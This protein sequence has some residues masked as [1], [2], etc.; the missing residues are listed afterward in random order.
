MQEANSAR[1]R[2][3]DFM[4]H[5][6]S[7]TK[8]QLEYALKLQ[9]ASRQPLGNILTELGFVEE[10]TLIDHLFKMVPPAYQKEEEN[11]EDTHSFSELETLVDPNIVPT[12]KMSFCR[13]KKLMPI[14]LDKYGKTLL[15]AMLDPTDQTTLQELRF[16][17]N[18]QVQPIKVNLKDLQRLWVLFHR[19][20]GAQSDQDEQRLSAQVGL[21]PL[22]PRLDESNVPAFVDAIIQQ[23]VAF[24]ASDVHIDPFQDGV[25]IRFRIDGALYPVCVLP[26]KIY[27]QVMT[28]FKVMSQMDISEQRRAQEG[29]IE[30]EVKRSGNRVDLRVAMIPTYFGERINFRILD[31]SG[32]DL[33]LSKLGI[34]E[35][36]MDMVLS[37]LAMRQG[38][39]LITGPTGSGKTTTIYSMLNH[40]ND[41]SR[42][43]M[44]IED[45][46]E[47]LVKGLNQIQID[48]RHDISFNSVL[49][50]LLR[51]NPDVILV[52]EIRDRETA[53]TAIR[54]ALTG[55][56]II[57]TV[58]TNDTST[59][60]ARLL[61]L[62]VEPYLLGPALQMVMAQRLVRKI[63]PHCKRHSSVPVRDLLRVGVKPVEVGDTPFYEGEGCAKCSYTGILGVSG[64]YEVMPITK[65]LRE[66]IMQKAP[67]MQI[68]ALALRQGMVPLRAGALSKAIC[69]ETTLYE[70]TRVAYN[71]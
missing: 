46:V 1:P 27:K 67:A 43:I 19:P 55:H 3:G 35:R 65:A 31:K 36:E 38:L 56:L 66:K 62:G 29:R 20:D 60:I 61:D 18:L 48:E 37:H 34:P 9:T 12:V 45:P 30:V 32:I 41:F 2:L 40:L 50:Y 26:H 33:S 7:L 28:R 6:G 70:T 15:V 11:G 64:V 57:A 8:E 4:V 51:H 23:A 17:T 53:E 14:V 63:C 69:G 22:V 58:H 5:S 68:R 10:E 47:Y 71:I 59:A 13:D 52:G 21:Q 24:R 44:T 54:A 16:M 49:K 39:I 42:N 25:M